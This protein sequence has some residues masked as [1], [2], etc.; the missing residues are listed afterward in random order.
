M[1]ACG[2]ENPGAMYA[3]LRLPAAQV[4]EIAASLGQAY[5]VNYNCP[6]QIV[7]ACVD[8]IGPQLSEAVNAAGGKALRLPVSGG[9][10]SPLMDEAVPPLEDFLATMSFAKPTMPLY[11][12]VTAQVY[13]DPR[14]ALSQQVNH[15]VLWQQTIENMI[16][17]GF[18]TF[19]EV[20]PGKTLSGFISKTN[21]G[22]RVLAVHD[23]S[24]LANTMEV[25]S[26]A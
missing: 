17:D 26:H 22:V 20:G 9:F 10:H 5:P 2:Q 3:V 7:V 1:H 16:D 6:G 24:S 12:N 15:P 23:S 13:D 4:E 11:S 14:T 21:A 18:D 8:Q 25:L 19:V